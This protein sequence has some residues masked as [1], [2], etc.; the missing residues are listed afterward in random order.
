MGK[1]HEVG[2]S[3]KK[4]KQENRAIVIKS[5]N[6][7]CARLL[8][9]TIAYNHDGDRVNHTSIVQSMGTVVFR[10]FLDVPAYVTLFNFFHFV[11]TFNHHRRRGSCLGRAGHRGIGRGCSGESPAPGAEARG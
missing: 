3:E 5:K 8:C 2:S 9:T 7:V 6:K 10:F 1:R 4:R 11:G